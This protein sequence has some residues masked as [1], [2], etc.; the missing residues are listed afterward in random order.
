MKWFTVLLVGEDTE[1]K[2]I[3]LGRMD[4]HLSA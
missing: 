3:G 4:Q 2:K 1:G